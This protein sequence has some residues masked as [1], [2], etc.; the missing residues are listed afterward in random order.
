MR[1]QINQRLNRY[2]RVFA[3]GFCFAVFGLGGL[4]ARCVIYPALV[5]CIRSQQRRISI[6]Q[7]FIHFGFKRFIGL[8]VGMGVLTYELHGAD[9]LRRRGLLVLANH[10][11]LIDVVFLMSFV[12]HANCIVK[13]QLARNPYTSGPVRAA[14]FIVN[15]GGAALLDDCVTTL[16]AGNNLIIFPEGT[17]TPLHGPIRLQRGAANIAVRG[18]IDVTPVHIHS[19]LPML[20]KGLPWWQVPARRPHFTITVKDDIPVSTFR[21]ASNEPLAARRL[22]EHLSQSLFMESHRVVA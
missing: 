2:W 1:E 3:T 20:P 5:L 14:G 18:N 8:M 9:K 4:M 12:R 22:T 13:E 11:S 10:P 19:S 6:S 16:G 21:D 17:R 15:D 7:D